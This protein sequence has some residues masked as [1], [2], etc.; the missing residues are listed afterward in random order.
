MGSNSPENLNRVTR[1]SKSPKICIVGAGY[2]T[3]KDNYA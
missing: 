2:E 3:K 1:M